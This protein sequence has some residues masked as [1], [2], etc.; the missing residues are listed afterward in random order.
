MAKK[1]SIMAKFIVAL[2][3]LLGLIA[4]LDIITGTHILQSLWN[5]FISFWREMGNKVGD[6][7]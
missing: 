4:I 1:G 2:L 7:A 5:A 6:V 3:A